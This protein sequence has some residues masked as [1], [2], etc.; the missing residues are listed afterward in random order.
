MSSLVECLQLG[1]HIEALGESNEL[2]RLV[3]LLYSK[4]MVPVSEWNGEMVLS[5]TVAVAIRALPC[6]PD[7]WAVVRQFCWR[8]FSAS[9]LPQRQEK[10]SPAASAA[11][12]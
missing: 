8:L 5:M 6:A 2:R 9:G 4:V 3:V 12:D 7:I 1:A 10:R 11:V